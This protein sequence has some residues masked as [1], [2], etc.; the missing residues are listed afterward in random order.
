MD[1]IREDEKI[2]GR[3]VIGVLDGWN[4][5]DEANIEIKNYSGLGG[6]KTFKLKCMD[7]TPPE[8]AFHCRSKEVIGLSD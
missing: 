7:A 4:H 5:V 6:S 1:A 2:L 3:F 8:I